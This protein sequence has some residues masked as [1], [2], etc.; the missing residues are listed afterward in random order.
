V[1]IIR[2]KENIPL[3]PG[4]RKLKQFRKSQSSFNTQIFQTQYELGNT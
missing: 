2:E 4:S 1:A 3:I